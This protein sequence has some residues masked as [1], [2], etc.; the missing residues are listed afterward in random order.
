MNPKCDRTAVKAKERALIPKAARVVFLPLLSFFLPQPHHIECK[1]ILQE[2][3]QV[4]TPPTKFAHLQGAPEARR[5][6]KAAKK[7][8]LENIMNA[9]RKRLAVITIFSFVQT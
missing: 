7:S 6:R 5:T 9:G 1:I 4:R 8:I 2:L 3:E